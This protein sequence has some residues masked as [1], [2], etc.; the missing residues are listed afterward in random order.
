MKRKINK[1]TITSC[2]NCI[3]AEYQQKNSKD[4]QKDI[5]TQIGCLA[6]RF[7]YFK[8]ADINIVEAYDDGDKEF[9]LIE[10]ICRYHRNLGWQIEKEQRDNAWIKQVKEEIKIKYDLIIFFR[11]SL[12]NL[13]TTLNS[14]AKFSYKPESVILI[15]KS[16]HSAD[17][18]SI[19]LRTLCLCKNH[20]GAPAY[21][22]SWKIQGI[23]D[24][25]L[26]DNKCIDLLQLRQPY[27]FVCNAGYVIP[28]K[29]MENISNAVNDDFLDFAMIQDKENGVKLVPTIVHKTL[30][31][32]VGDDLEKKIINE[33]GEKK[34]I[35]LKKFI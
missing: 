29:L 9:Y 2:K 26:P 30:G 19:R 17:D 28:S 11:D 33:G 7:P 35:S 21:F 8:K 32:N 22:S 23:V 25:N 10:G 15:N 1:V 14:L 5:Q 18:L 34:L 27:Y 4:K 31:G 3:F 13:A 6:G 16:N 24:K 20:G 12:K